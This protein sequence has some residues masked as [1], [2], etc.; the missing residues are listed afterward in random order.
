[1]VRTYKGVNIWPADRNSSGIRW[2]ATVNG[3]RLRADTLA[4]IKE[5][6]TDQLALWGAY[7]A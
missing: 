1:M 2:T 5:L 3:Y 6:I 7:S 4:G